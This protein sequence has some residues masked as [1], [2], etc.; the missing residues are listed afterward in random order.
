MKKPNLTIILTIVLVLSTL[1][2]MAQAPQMFK[3]QAVLRDA[4]G[5]I[6]A[7][8][9]KTVVVDILQS[10]LTTSVFTETHHVTTTSLGLIN[11]NIGSVSGLSGIDW[12]AD[13]YFIRITVDGTVMGTSQL[14]SVPYALNSKKVEI[15]NDPLYNGSVA[16][17]I[18]SPDIVNWNN[19][20]GW[21]NHSLA[22]Y[23]TGYTETDPIFGLSVAFGITSTDITNWNNKLSSFTE[24]DPIFA[25]HVSYGITSND[26]TNWNNK[27]GSFTETDPIF[28]N[29]VSHGITSGDITNW[30]NK[31]S[32]FTETD[33][34]FAIHVAHGITTTNITNWNTAY[35]WGKGWSLTGNS[36]TG[37]TNFIGTTDNNSLVFITNNIERLRITTTGGVVL[38]Q[39]L[40]NTNRNEFQVNR[41]RINFSSSANDN[42][43]VIYNNG[44]N[45]DG[46]GAWDGLKMNVYRG[47]NIRL[48]NNGVYSAFYID[49]IG[50]IGIGNTNPL[51]KM[52][53]DGDLNITGKYKVNGV[54]IVY[55]YDGSET[56]VTGANNIMVTGT[57]TTAN[58]YVVKD[59]YHYIGESFGGGIVFYVYDN[60][61][62]GLIVSPE[63]SS[64]APW[65]ISYRSTYAVKSGIG[66]GAINNERIITTQGVSVGYAAQI[67]A[68]YQGGNFADWYL[69]SLY[70]LQLIWQVYASVG[71]SSDWAYWSS[72]EYNADKAWYMHFYNGNVDYVIKNPATQPHIIGVRQF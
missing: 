5:N 70:E 48:G 51:Y 21:G 20:Y 68:N 58:P 72:T 60:G 56:K 44:N 19:A 53:V 37:S 47:L 69:P 26:I 64:G 35:S 49:I 15:E 52:D 57:G 8:Q 59:V 6:I 30:N 38:P 17:G 16:S 1:G 41:G 65:D 23:I 45:I 43:H 32:S 39:S 71:L 31:L 13:E 10:N 33:P 18:T 54:D 3:Y 28:V 25:T 36:G 63:L 11:L 34:V 55:Q 22:G 42:N 7:N 67:C 24:T 12:S 4:S 40:N 14:L 46:E 66:G 27:L 62:H 50:N 2:L 29:H 9:N 61:R